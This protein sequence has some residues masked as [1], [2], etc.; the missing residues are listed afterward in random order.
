M[1][2]VPGSC[3]GIMGQLILLDGLM[4][5]GWRKRDI[6]PFENF[7]PEKIQLMTDTVFEEISK[8][9]LIDTFTK[10]FQKIGDG[11]VFIV[12]AA[13]MFALLAVHATL[14]AMHAPVMFL[15]P[16]ISA[17]ERLG[18]DRKMRRQRHVTSDVHS[19]Q[20]LQRRFVAEWIKPILPIDIPGIT[21]GNGGIQFHVFLCNH[22]KIADR[23]AVLSPVV[24][25]IVI[26][27]QKLI[28][29][30]VECLLEE[31][32]KCITDI[33]LGSNFVLT[34][35]LHFHPWQCEFQFVGRWKRVSVVADACC[36]V[37][38]KM[39]YEWKTI[40]RMVKFRIAV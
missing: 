14:L 20:D 27:I 21:D 34:Q 12:A 2:I 16:S 23:V 31:R 33:E 35:K 11:H 17:A 30:K 26:H 4:V 6:I 3:I 1:V 29:V 32:F 10:I 9:F 38:G 7:G 36:I 28:N 5:T 15:G 19:S 40:M 8:H 39:S 24:Q 18:R 37:G 25:V 22:T 13:T